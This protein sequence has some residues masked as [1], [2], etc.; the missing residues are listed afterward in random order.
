MYKRQTI[1]L[2]SYAKSLNIADGKTIL[3]QA[4]EE[5]IDYPC[6]CKSGNCGACKSELYS[7]EVELAPYSEF[8]LTE[9]EKKQNLILA[10]RAI[11]LSD[12][13]LSPLGQ[14]EIVNHPHR[15]MNSKISE[16]I[17]STHDIYIVRTKIALGEVYDFSPGQYSSLQFDGMPPRDFSMANLPGKNE[18]EFHIRQ[19]AN[20]TVS[21]HILSNL[22][23]GDNVQVDGPYG[24][25]YL[26]ESH[27]GPIICLLY[28]SPSP[29]A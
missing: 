6:G 27:S 7:G 2:R 1:N 26:R 3:E 21:Q 18:L 16:I 11:P 23:V 9:E 13:E 22:K 29:R 17:K 10:C 4:L 28:T 19:V 14:D 15:S 8:A 5:G 12:C 25:S 20:G 24:I